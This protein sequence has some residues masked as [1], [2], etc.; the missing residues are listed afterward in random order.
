[1]RYFLVMYAYNTNSTWGNGFD[2]VT[3]SVGY[4]NNEQFRKNVIANN[5]EI[6]TVVITNIIE[7]KESDFND[8]K[9]E[10]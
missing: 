7:L 4:V 3:V 1:M 8:F 5:S 6:K 2:Y 10:D 9:K